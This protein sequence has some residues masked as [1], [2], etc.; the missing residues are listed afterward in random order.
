[1]SENLNENLH[2]K[3]RQRVRDEF[4][5]RGFSDDTP[6]HKILEMLLFFSIPRIDTNKLAHILINNFGS[7]SKVLDASPEELMKVKGIGENSAALIKLMIP[8]IRAYTNDKLSRQKKF[9][10]MDEIGS[11]I[12][13]KYLGFTNEVFAV[14]SL[15]NRGCPIKFD[16]VSEG[17]L[18]SVAVS[19]RTVIE[20]VIKRGATAVVLSHNH[21]GGQAVPSTADIKTTETLCTALNNINVKVLDHIILCDDDYV[22]LALSQ[23]YRHLFDV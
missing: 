17:D 19:T 21:P 15:D 2:A 6:D 23:S 10:D 5:A 18:E 3:H 11:Y 12:E 20:T 14:T 1:M 8:V 9:E 7:F 22:S 13:H 16:I 4:F